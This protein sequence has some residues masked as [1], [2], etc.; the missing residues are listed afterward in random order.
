MS[1]FIGALDSG[2]LRKIGRT[3]G[4]T[5]GAGLVGQQFESTV[6]AASA[7]SL[8]TGVAASVTY[9][10]LTAGNWLVFGCA[11]IRPDASTDTT[12]EHC[13]IGVSVAY[14]ARLGETRRHAAY[15]L[16]ANNDLSLVPSTR[17]LNLTAT[18]RVYLVALVDFS[19]GTAKAYGSLYAERIATA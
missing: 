1:E 7:V 3:D 12:R 11:V 16:G 15:V 6:L 14:T 9:L 4:A 5:I 2:A 17:L 8:S 19:A 10:D 13:N 18:T